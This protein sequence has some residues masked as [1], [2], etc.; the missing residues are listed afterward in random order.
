V[1]WAPD[2]FLD[3][4]NHFDCS[5]STSRTV[6]IRYSPSTRLLFT[7]YPAH[8]VRAAAAATAATAARAPVAPP[9]CLRLLRTLCQHIQQQHDGSTPYGMQAA[10][11]YAGTCLRCYA[12]TCLHCY[13]GTCLRCLS[14]CRLQV[15]TLLTARLAALWPRA[16]LLIVLLLMPRPF[17]LT[18]G[19]T[20]ALCLHIDSLT[21][22][23]NLSCLARAQH[24]LHIIF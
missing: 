6:Q 12:G 10:L 22:R 14:R 23:T 19:R 8:D 11:S 4:H 2:R 7:A 17:R 21:M 20:T 3:A 15:H 9:A 16:A 1:A 18:S 5:P 13:A 24:R